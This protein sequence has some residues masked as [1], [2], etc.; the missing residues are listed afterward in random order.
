[1]TNPIDLVLDQIDQADINICCVCKIP[2]NYKINLSCNDILC[3]ECSEKY[4]SNRKIHFCP[5]CDKNLDFSI[6]ELYDFVLSNKF[7]KLQYYYGINVNFP[8]WIYSTSNQYWIYSKFNIDIIESAYNTYIE[9]HRH[10]K[11]EIMIDDSIYVINFVSNK[12]ISKQTNKEIN[13]L[14]LPYLNS[15][16]IKKYKIIGVSGKLL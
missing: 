4:I 8:I 5:E 6:R 7:I 9:N 16:L 2:P 1:M 12:Q 15:N 11:I 13:I 10:N 14:R 3:L